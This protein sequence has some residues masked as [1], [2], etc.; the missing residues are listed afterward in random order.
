MDVA[1]LSEVR[2]PHVSSR[3]IIK[4]GSQQRYWLYH[5][6]VS[7][8]SGRNG[9]AIVTSEKAR[10]ALIEWKPVNDRMA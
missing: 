1:C 6:S 7:N 3:V 4:P 5:S 8:N 2:L 10:S 9:V